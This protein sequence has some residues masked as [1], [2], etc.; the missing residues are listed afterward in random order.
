[1]EFCQKCDGAGVL[2]DGGYHMVCQKCKGSGII[3]D[4]MKSLEWD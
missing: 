4:I 2:N 1:V 3:A